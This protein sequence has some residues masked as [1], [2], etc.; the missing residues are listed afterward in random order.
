MIKILF[1]VVNGFRQFLWHVFFSL[2]HWLC[3]IG[4]P[5]DTQAW[6]ETYHM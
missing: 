2:A 4:Y 5:W 3:A 6:I 1:R